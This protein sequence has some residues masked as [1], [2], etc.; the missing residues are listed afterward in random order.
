ME[1]KVTLEVLSNLTNKTL[2]GKLADKEVGRLLVPTDLT[3]R[4]SSWAVPVGLLHASGG[5][6]GLASCLGGE[7]LAGGLAS[8]RLACCLLGTGHCVAVFGILCDE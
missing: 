7:L 4:D 5:R 8:G 1:A 3:K 6:G 2:E